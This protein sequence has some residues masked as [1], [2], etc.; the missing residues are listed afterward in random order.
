MT[1]GEQTVEI[2]VLGNRVLLGP[3]EY[4]ISAQDDSDAIN[5][6]V[7]YKG[8]KINDVTYIVRRNF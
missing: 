8:E 3:C 1:K 4:I 5:Y 2:T 6:E 7:F